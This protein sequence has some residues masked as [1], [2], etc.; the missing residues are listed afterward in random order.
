MAGNNS[1]GIDSSPKEMLLRD[2][3]RE[4]ILAGPPL[5]IQK[6]RSS[7][8]D[9]GSIDYQSDIWRGY[10]A[11]KLGEMLR[12]QRKKDWFVSKPMHSGFCSRTPEVLTE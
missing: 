10:S 4:G 6:T 2:I 11:S 12:P 1:T 5:V 9:A 3:A 7:M 8:T